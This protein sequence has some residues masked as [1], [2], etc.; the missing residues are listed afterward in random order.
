MKD[1]QRGNLFFF[2][3]LIVVLGL[4]LFLNYYLSEILNLKLGSWVSH[5]KKF[6]LL[7]VS[8]EQN[9]HT[10]SGSVICSWWII[11]LTIHPISGNTVKIDFKKGIWKFLIQSAITVFCEINITNLVGTITYLLSFKSRTKLVLEL[12]G[13]FFFF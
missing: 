11:Y 2:L 8:S 10:I 3:F 12:T 1:W 4:H 6:S 5:S 9:L 13:T 7:Q